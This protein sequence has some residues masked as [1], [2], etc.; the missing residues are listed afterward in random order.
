MDFSKVQLKSVGAPKQKEAPKVVLCEDSD[1][2]TKLM[3]ETYLEQYFASIEE[4]T[5]RSLFVKL[6]IPA[7]KAIVNVHSI[8]KKDST[9]EEWKNSEEFIVLAKDIENA[10]DRLGTKDVFVRLSSRS[11]KDA[12]LN[13]PKFMEIFKARLQQLKLEHPGADHKNLA[14]ISL[15]QASTSSLSVNTGFEAIKLLLESDRIQGDI[16]RYIEDTQN[17]KQV[18]FN[19]VVREF[20]NFD[21]SLEFR[22]FIYNRKLTA[23]TQYNEFVFFESLQTHKD[24]ILGAIVQFFEE[25]L[26]PKIAL[27]NFVVDFLLIQEGP[28]YDKLRTYVVEI[29]PF[30]EF[31]GSGLFSWIDDMDTLIGKKPFEFRI[32]TKPIE[33][34]EHVLPAGWTVFL[35]E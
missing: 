23:L 26:I 4:F 34:A 24:E 22:G 18:D 30:A 16:E 21:V 3:E 20:K 6:T 13:S 35:K 28:G 19:V 27:K 17:G 8:V 7:A 11:P 5:F 1:Q 31:A 29:N 10:R 33:F 25:K 12:A 9:Y 2:Y 32:A 14:L 15:Y